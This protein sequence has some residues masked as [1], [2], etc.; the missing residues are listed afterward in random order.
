[1]LDRRQRIAKKDDYDLV[2]RLGKGAYCEM[3]RLK[4]RNNEQGISRSGIIASSKFS[5]SAARRNR[6]KRQ[7]R[8]VVRKNIGKIKPGYDLVIMAQKSDGKTDFKFEEIEK[9][10]I[11]TLKK[12]NLLD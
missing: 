10:L 3:I 4:Y 2:Y 5:N 9:S 12:A 8:E 7:I 6:I 11:K 1:M